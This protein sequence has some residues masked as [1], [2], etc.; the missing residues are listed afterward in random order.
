MPI[1]PERTRVMLRQRFPT[2]PLLSAVLQ[3]PGSMPLLTWL[4]RNWNYKV[5]REAYAAIHDRP[6]ADGIRN[7]LVERIA[8]ICGPLEVRAMKHADPHVIV[9]LS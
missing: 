4:V 6:R 3:L 1:A 5:A 9:C 2:G 8:A 7:D